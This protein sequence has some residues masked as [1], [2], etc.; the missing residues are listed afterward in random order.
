MKLKYLIITFY[1]N[2][3]KKRNREDTVKC[4]VSNLIDESSSDLM[5]EFC[6]EIQSDE[7]TYGDSNAVSNFE[8]NKNWRLWQPDPVDA[9]PGEFSL[10]NNQFYFNKPKIFIFK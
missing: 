2:F 3:V 6:K 9:N 7:A 4:I 10:I 1:F 5:E 8:L